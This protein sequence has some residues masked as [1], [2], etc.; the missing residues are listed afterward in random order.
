[1]QF[2]FKRNTKTNKMQIMRE[3][4]DDEAN[5]QKLKKYS[6]EC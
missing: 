4:Y 2:K 5:L 3:K 1:M 6:I